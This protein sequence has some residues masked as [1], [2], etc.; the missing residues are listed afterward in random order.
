MN[1]ERR[2][3]TNFFQENIPNKEKRLDP[4]ITY[5]LIAAIGNN[6]AKALLL[7]AMQKDQVYSNSKLEE[8][9]RQ[10]Q[11]KEQAWPRPG[12][13]LAQYCHQTLEPAGLVQEIIG[14]HGVVSGYMK[15]EFAEQT[16][17]AL[18]G[19]LLEFSE[20]HQ[21]PLYN[22]F[23]ATTSNNPA[24]SIKIKNTE[25]EL[26][27]KKRAAEVRM[28]IFREIIK[29]PPNTTTT[30]LARACGETTKRIGSH[31]E[32]LNRHSVVSYSHYVPGIDYGLHQLS[33]KRPADPPKP[34]AKCA[35]LTQRVYE[36]LQSN[37]NKQFTVSE[38]AQIIENKQKKPV[39]EDT[40]RAILSH[41]YKEGYTEKDSSHTRINLTDQQ[42]KLI[43]DLVEKIDSFERQ[44][45]NDLN[46]WK[47]TARKI[48]NNPERVNALL[49]R[50]KEASPWAKRRPTAETTNA[51]CELLKQNPELTAT[52][53][54]E[55]LQE[56]LGRSYTHANITLLLKQLE[57]AGVIRVD[58]S[59]RPPKYRINL[60]AI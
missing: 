36:I 44:N 42:R 27:A 25:D 45:P 6:E 14:E 33:T 20:Q 16:G 29:Q 48:V 11:G 37:P 12:K 38:I 30:A 26:D 24:E 49:E 43:T 22:L 3:Q 51:I 50:A 18:A 57:K 21:V 32:E 54:Q 41:L 5:T 55:K 52:E 17:E 9:F 10:I 7:T 58:K 4:R 1:L 35:P 28:K 40:V 34:F 23:G 8:I 53:I 15:T 46:N 56:R 39:A 60:S 47:D 31:L 59:Q 2:G 19:L 13:I